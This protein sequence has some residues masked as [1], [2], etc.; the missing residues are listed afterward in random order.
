L[1]PMTLV[2]K[3]PACLLSGLGW[4]GG[5]NAFQ[6]LNP[7]HLVGADRVRSGLFRQHRRRCIGGADRLHRNDEMGIVLFLGVE[8]ITDAV[9]LDRLSGAACRNKLF[10]E[11]NIRRKPCLNRRA[12]QRLASAIKPT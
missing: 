11:N 1:R 5:G 6:R 9:G 8:P 2:F 4:L 10:R 3:L 7:G 12:V